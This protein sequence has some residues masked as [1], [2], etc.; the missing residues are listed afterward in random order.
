M[1]I[2][3]PQYTGCVLDGIDLI[4]FH[5]LSE[6][7]KS[8]LFQFSPARR[9]L[10]PKPGKPDLRPL[11]IASPRQKIV[12]K[13]IQMT[14]ATI[15]EPIFLD[16]SHGFRPGR[17]CHTAL[18][19]VQLDMGTGWVWALEGNIKGCFDNIPHNVT[20]HLLRKVIDCP[21]TIQLIKR[22]LEAGY[23]DCVSGKLVRPSLG[24]PQGSVL[25]PLLSNIVLHELDTYIQKQLIPSFNCGK[26]RKG[27]PEYR[28]AKY[29]VEKLK[30]V[31]A[32]LKTRRKTYRKLLTIPSGDPMDPNF[33]RAGYIRY[34]D[35]WIMLII[36]SR[37]DALHLK[38]QIAHKLSTLGLTLSDAK[39][40]I[41]KLNQKSANFLGF[42]IHS[43]RIS[44]DLMKPLRLVVRNGTKYRRRNTPRL[45]LE[46]PIETIL[47]KL[48]KA[49]FV[50]RNH[51][52]SLFPISYTTVLNLPHRQI[53]HFYNSKVRGILN[54]YSCAHNRSRLWSAVTLLK[55]SCAITLAHKFKL[56]GRTAAKAFQ[57]FGPLLTVQDSTKP[58][59][60][61]VPKNLQILPESKRFS[62]GDLSNIDTLLKG[63]M[64]LWNDPT[65]I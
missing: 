52:G 24:T 19:Q 26:V 25:S 57:K 7:L 8:G 42:R 9:V 51:M 53:L 21:A 12:Q 43:R 38:A 56:G 32:D 46:A 37:T 17:S 34:A 36:G 3:Y 11:G 47:E 22:S 49:G 29:E 39:T 10:I 40:V 4:F 1:G 59:S 27:N 65:T 14:L 41:T 54:Y 15:Y 16:C 18:R 23:I 2:E 28:H 35:D 48:C 31:Y 20:L 13:A 45:I 55:L 64:D 62:K 30:N 61:Y 6:S 60:F 33:K 58:V 5:K 44:E 63:G 50:R